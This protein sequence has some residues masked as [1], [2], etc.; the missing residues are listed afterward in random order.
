MEILYKAKNA[1]S[2]FY[3]LIIVFFLKVFPDKKLQ[4]AIDLLKDLRKVEEA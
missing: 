2:E 1:Y 3:G 4:T